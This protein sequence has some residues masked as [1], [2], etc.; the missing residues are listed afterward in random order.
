MIGSEIYLFQLTQETFLV[1]EEELGE[2]KNNQSVLMMYKES[3][4]DNFW[5]RASRIH[6]NIANKVLKI[7]QFSITYICEESFS[8]MTNLKSMKCWSLNT[9]DDEMLLSLSYI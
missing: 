6:L 3:D 7:L 2:I 4:W 8:T 9:L 1:E 5:V